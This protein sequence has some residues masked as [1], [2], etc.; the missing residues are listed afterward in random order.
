M[1]LAKVVFDKIGATISAHSHE[2]DGEHLIFVLS[3]RFKVFD[4]G[5]LREV[6]VGEFKYFAAGRQHAIQAL[7]DNS[8]YLNLFGWE[9]QQV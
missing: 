3:G 9:V 8:S 5:E 6:S 2:E 4:D 7:A 1:R